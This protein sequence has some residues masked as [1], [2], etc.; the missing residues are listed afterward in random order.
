MIRGPHAYDP[1]HCAAC[2]VLEQ[3]YPL[4]APEDMSQLL[5]TG[6]R[7]GDPFVE[8]NV[9]PT[10]IQHAE[11]P[12]STTESPLHGHERRPAVLRERAPD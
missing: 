2:Q 3:R 9:R 6:F 1:E 5:A 12:T 11:P 4:E 7:R 8:A 10:Q